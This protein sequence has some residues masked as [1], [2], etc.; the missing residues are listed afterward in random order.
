L[1]PAR[2]DRTQWAALALLLAL[3]PFALTAPLGAQAAAPS[4]RGAAIAAY[5]AG[6]YAA[7]DALFAEAYEATGDRRLLRARGNCL[8]RLGELPRALW[9]FESARLGAPRD[10]ELRADIALVQRR[11]E[12]GDDAG[13]FLAELGRLRRRLSPV[14]RTLLLAACM[15]VAA[16]CLIGGWRRVGWRWVG[17]L[18]LLPGL[19]LAAEVLWLDAVR[20]PRAVAL[21]KLAI[22]SEPRAGLEPVATA[23]P[24]VEVDVL[25][26]TDGTFVRIAAGD[27]TGYVP[28]AAIAVV[29]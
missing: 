13:G 24:G 9:A 21:E 17:A 22:T 1:E 20:P 10:A 15:F 3:A 25:G 7:A 12:V 14:E 2:I 6:D 27:R 26:G 29:R 4:G 16:L 23:R 19:W 8:F 18:A 28:R 5:R 11:L